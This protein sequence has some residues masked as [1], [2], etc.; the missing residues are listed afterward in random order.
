MFGSYD[1][2][3]STTEIPEFGVASNA[4]FTF[5]IGYTGV[6]KWLHTLRLNPTLDEKKRKKKKKSGYAAGGVYVPCINLHAR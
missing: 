3:N 4:A 1:V 5:V 2:K 6:G